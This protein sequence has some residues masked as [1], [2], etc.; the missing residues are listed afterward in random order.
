M[1]SKETRR[2]D[3]FRFSWRRRRQR[4]DAN[5]SVDAVY[6]DIGVSIHKAFEI[7]V[8]LFGLVGGF[9]LKTARAM[10]VGVGLVRYYSVAPCVVN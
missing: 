4:G 3:D 10:D 8:A 2:H 9:F 1:G 7:V 5:G 6:I